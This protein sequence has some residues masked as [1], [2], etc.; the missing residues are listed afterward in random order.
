MNGVGGKPGW[1]WIFILEGL[2][3][4]LSGFA[5]FWLI[6]N[7]PDK[8][9]FLTD[10]DRYRV[11]ARLWRDKQA[12]AGNEG[13]NRSFLTA[14][15]VDWKMW[16]SM[17]IYCGCAMPLYAFSLFLPTI[18]SLCLEPSCPTSSDTGLN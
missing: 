13:F 5:S 17:A 4:V 7:F 18:V 14:G 9:K 1:A 11:L 6:E 15:L 12:A 16:L 8:A 3:T 2:L 10:A